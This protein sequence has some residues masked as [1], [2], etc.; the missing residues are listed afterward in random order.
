MGEPA[1]VG[2]PAEET[3]QATEPAAEKVAN[4]KPYEAPNS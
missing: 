1:P 4:Y 3:K 2:D